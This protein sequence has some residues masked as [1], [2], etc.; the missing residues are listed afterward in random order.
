MVKE[1]S[2]KRG[3]APTLEQISSDIITQVSD[4]ILCQY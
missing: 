4:A 3:A 2:Q 1:K